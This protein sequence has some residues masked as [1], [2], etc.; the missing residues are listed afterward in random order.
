MAKEVI[1]MINLVLVKDDMLHFG[2]DI[3]A[4]RGMGQNILNH[5]GILYRVRLMET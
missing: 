2:Q 4:V 3:R 1:S 5:H